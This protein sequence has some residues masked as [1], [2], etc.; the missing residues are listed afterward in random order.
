[1]AE[2]KEGIEIIVYTIG[3][4]SLVLSFVSP[5]AGLILG[6]VGLVHARNEKSPMIS[7]GKKLNIIGIVISIVMLILLVV[8]TVIPALNSSAIPGI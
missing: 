2:K 4:L 7:K 8:L 6:I 3:I 1:M 5:V